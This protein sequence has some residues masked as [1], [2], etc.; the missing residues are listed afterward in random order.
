MAKYKAKEKGYLN[1]QGIILKGQVFEYEGKPGKWMKPVDAKAEVSE[2]KAE[3]K[4]SP[5]S[6]K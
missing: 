1:K 2:P 3:V 5:K 4:D 6:K